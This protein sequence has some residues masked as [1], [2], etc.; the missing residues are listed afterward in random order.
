MQLRRLLYSF[1]LMIVLIVLASVTHHAAGQTLNFKQFTVN[2]G[3][4]SSTVYFTY[5]D[6]KGYMWFATE[7]GVNRFDGRTFESF[8]VDDGLSDNEILWIQEDSQHRIWFLTLS[9]QL[10][11]YKN[12]KFYNPSNHPLLK[13]AV[14]RSSFV[15]FFEDSKKRIWLGTNQQ[16]VVMIGNSRVTHYTLPSKLLLANSFV[17]EDNNGTIWVL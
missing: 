5:Q 9:G 3:L 13:K 2:N 7:A 1:R 15:S 12:G 8:T 4:L 17:V 11:F 6:S 14:T 16:D 10:S